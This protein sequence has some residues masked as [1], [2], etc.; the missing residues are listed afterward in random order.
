[1]ALLRL[2]EVMR[3][4]GYSR[5]ML[6]SLISQGLYPKPIKIGERAVAWPS[7]EVEIMVASIVSQ[8]PPGERRELVEK[9]EAN[10]G[11]S[12]SSV[13]TGGVT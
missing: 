12:F 8:Q 13:A 1:M 10:R 2:P 5:S 11:I 7:Q 9:L 6:Y 3:H 4:S